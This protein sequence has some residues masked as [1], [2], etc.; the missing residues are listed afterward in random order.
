MYWPIGS[1]NIAYTSEK[2]CFGCLIIL[3]LLNLVI[4]K[5]LTEK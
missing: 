2:N 1:E 4:I 3:M 5:P